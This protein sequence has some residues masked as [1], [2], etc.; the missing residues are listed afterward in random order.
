MYTLCIKLFFVKL[1]QNN[2]SFKFNFTQFFSL[3]KGVTELD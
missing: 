1:V 3:D 2:I